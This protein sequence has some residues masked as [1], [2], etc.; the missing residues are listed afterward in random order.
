MQVKNILLF[1]MQYFY[2][3]KFESR[4]K[5]FIRAILRNEENKHFKRLQRKG[6]V[7]KVDLQTLKFRVDNQSIKANNFKIITVSDLMLVHHENYYKTNPS[8]NRIKN[9]KIIPFIRYDYD[10][11]FLYIICLNKKD[12]ELLRNNFLNISSWKYKAVFN[13]E[14]RKIIYG[15]K[16]GFKKYY[17]YSYNLMYLQDMETSIEELKEEIKALRKNKEQ[18]SE[19]I[20]LLKEQKEQGIVYIKNP[21]MINYEVYISELIRTYMGMYYKISNMEEKLEKKEKQYNKLK[22]GEAEEENSLTDYLQEDYI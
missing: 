20:D 5:K 12:Y 18:L 19:E 21:L 6:Y 10:I 16:N 7:L 8:F 4:N 14:E 1:I 3:M 13:R 9:I 17:R 2:C 15:M 22:Y 11:S